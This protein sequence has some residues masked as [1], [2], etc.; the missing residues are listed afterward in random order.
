[1]AEGGNIRRSCLVSYELLQ[2]G[3]LGKNG[4]VRDFFAEG[5]PL[6][7]RPLGQG[8]KIC[9][10][11][12]GKVEMSTCC[13]CEIPWDL[14]Q[15]SEAAT[16]ELFT[17]VDPSFAFGQGGGRIF[18]PGWIRLFPIS[19]RDGGPS[20]HCLCFLRRFCDPSQKAHERPQNARERTHML[21]TRA[22]PK[23]GLAATFTPSAA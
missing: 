23:I 12:A 18:V 5:Q 9:N 1:M 14:R 8:R 20:Y 10:R 22:S 13:F 17:R 15:C 19:T 11:R 7:V 3:Q 2:C 21:C 4:D 6:D 16:P